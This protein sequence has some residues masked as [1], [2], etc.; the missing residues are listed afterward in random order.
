MVHVA[1][2]VGAEGLGQRYFFL[3]DLLEAAPE[4]DIVTHHDACHLRKYA[5][6]RARL[7]CR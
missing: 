4:I 3:A 1:E 2:F 6:S 7:A 5:A